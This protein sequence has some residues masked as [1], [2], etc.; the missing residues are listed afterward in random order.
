M[1]V[2]G[3]GPCKLRMDRGGQRTADSQRQLAWLI[4]WCADPAVYR[5][6]VLPAP[7]ALRLHSGT[8]SSA[9]SLAARRRPKLYT[10]DRLA[11]YSSVESTIDNVVHHSMRLTISPCR[12]VFGS[13]CIPRYLPREVVIRCNY[14]REYLFKP[15]RLLSAALSQIIKPHM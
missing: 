6:I 10:Q 14:V 7:V 5:S 12:N 13:Q 4:F 8:F 9:H 1:K 3:R 2:K 15:H 11:R